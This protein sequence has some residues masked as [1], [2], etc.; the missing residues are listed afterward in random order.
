MWMDCDAWFNTFEISLDAIID[1][2]MKDKSMLLARD[3]GVM[4]KPC[5]YHSCLI[6][7]GVLLFK[8]NDISMKIIRLWSNPSNEL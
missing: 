1:T 5:F 3:H 7:S 2:F 6:N 4:N 8:C